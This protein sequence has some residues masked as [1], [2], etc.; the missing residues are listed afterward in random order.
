MTLGITLFI[1]FF[2][3]FFFFLLVPFLFSCDSLIRRRDKSEGIAQGHSDRPAAIIE[4]HDPSHMTQKRHAGRYRHV[5]KIKYIP[6]TSCLQQKGLPGTTPH[7]ALR[8]ACSPRMLPSTPQGS[9]HAL[10][11]L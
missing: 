6:L 10:L 9:R 2:I 11:S 8:R 7:P 5:E 1:F 3:Y 4:A